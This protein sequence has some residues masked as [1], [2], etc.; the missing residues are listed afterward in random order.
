MTKKFL[1]L[2][3]VAFAAT[4]FVA[5]GSDDDDGGNN[6]NNNGNTKTNSI[7]A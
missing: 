1:Y 7:K 2:A 3:M 6:N 4:A 5:C